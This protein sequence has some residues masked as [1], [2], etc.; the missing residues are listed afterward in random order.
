MLTCQIGIA[1]FSAFGKWGYLKRLFLKKKYSEKVTAQAHGLIMI[2]IYLSISESGRPFD[3]I[4][5]LNIQHTL[6]VA[7]I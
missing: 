1:Y 7:L 5:H 4:D 2:R 3:L 6:Y